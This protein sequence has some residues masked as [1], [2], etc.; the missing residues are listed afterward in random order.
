MSDR[1][2]WCVPLF[3]GVM[4]VYSAVSRPKPGAKWYGRLLVGLVGIYLFYVSTFHVFL[5]KPK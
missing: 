3:L 5:P 1:I 4:L 2:V